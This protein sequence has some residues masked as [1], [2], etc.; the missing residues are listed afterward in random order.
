M[1]LVMRQDGTVSPLRPTDLKEV[2]ERDE[3]IRQ[4]E[5]LNATL[6][7][8]VGRMRPVVDAA[9][10]WNRTNYR[11]LKECELALDAIGN[12]CDAYEQAGQPK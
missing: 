7:A 11:D 2:A 8:E 1:V 6:S 12:A 9:L 4:L 5:K 10:T 3:R